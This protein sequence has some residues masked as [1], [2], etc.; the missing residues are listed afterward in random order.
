M[1]KLIIITAPSGSGKSTIVK[2]LLQTFP[3]LALSVSATTRARRSYE[4][5]GREYYFIPV[6]R[7]SQYLRQSRFVEWEEVYPGQFY[8]TLK[9][10]LKRL[11]ALRKIIIFDIDVRGAK[12]LKR[13]FP[14][15]SLAIFIKPPSLGVLRQRLEARNTETPEK[16]AVRMARASMEMDFE[17]RF[18]AV[19]MND[20][21]ETAKKEI[22][23]LIEKFIKGK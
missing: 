23:L 4:A 7:F 6:S 21:L 9:S 14:K 11:W 17:N 10:E 8:G 3:R 16:I 12:D 5:D 1:G 15:N 13:M 22:E 19:V 18:D 20:D 2:H